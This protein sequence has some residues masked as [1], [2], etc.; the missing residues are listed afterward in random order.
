MTDWPD[1]VHRHGPLVWRIAQR[2][3]G[4]DADAR[5]CFQQTFLAAVE[6]DNRSPVRDWPAA[7]RRIA[8]ARALDLLRARYRWRRSDS[9][10]DGLPDSD[11]EDPIGVAAHGELADRLRQALA[12]IDPTHAAAFALVALDGLSNTE[13]ADVLGV[14]ANHVGVMLHRARQQL[15]AR[16]IA[17]DPTTNWEA[18]P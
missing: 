2:L 5:D 3:L 4:H 6:W 14:S 8:T 15:R 7:L 17:F 10:P 1:I 13:A 16:L 11:L 12:A 18:T 9:L